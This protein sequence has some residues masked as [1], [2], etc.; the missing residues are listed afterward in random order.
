MHANWEIYYFRCLKEIYYGNK[1]PSCKLIYWS[2]F[3]FFLQQ[4]YWHFATTLNK[5]FELPD[6]GSMFYNYLLSFIV[7]TFG[8][9][10]VW[11]AL[12]KVIN[13]PLLTL[14]AIGKF[15]IFLISLFCWTNDTISFRAFFRYQLVT[16]FSA[17]FFLV[18]LFSKRVVS[19]DSISCQLIHA[20]L[21]DSNLHSD[22][23]IQ[24]A[25][26]IKHIQ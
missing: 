22:I 4:L 8:V 14:S 18:A 9:V 21:T 2:S 5:A 7:A 24:S 19:F 13:R 1:S 16:L 25:L 17:A 12:Q 6:P 23:P 3:Q 26:N 15:G 10:Y 11:L 20:V